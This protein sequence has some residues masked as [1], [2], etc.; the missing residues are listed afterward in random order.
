MSEGILK[1][2]NIGD[3]FADDATTSS[4]IDRQRP[5]FDSAHQIDLETPCKVT[6]MLS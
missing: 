6:C 1:S 3:V 4:A 2:G 5:Q